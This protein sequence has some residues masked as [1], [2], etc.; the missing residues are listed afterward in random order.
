MNRPDRPEIELREYI[1][2]RFDLLKE[3]LAARYESQQAALR[4]ADDMQTIRYESQEKALSLAD[5]TMKE[6]LDRMNEFREQITD[7]R[8]QYVTRKELLGIISAVAT[9]VGVVVS[10]AAKVLG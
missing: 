5:Q 2:I 10:I 9:I 7:E 8:G 1:D 4:L 3:L 6:R